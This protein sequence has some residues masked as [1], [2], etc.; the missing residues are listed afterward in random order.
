LK[1]NSKVEIMKRII[2]III[3]KNNSMK[4]SSMLSL[5]YTNKSHPFGYPMRMVQNST[6]H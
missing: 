2:M 3:M 6:A 4:M 5:F 1:K